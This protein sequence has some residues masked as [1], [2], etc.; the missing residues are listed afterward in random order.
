MTPF[1][2]GERI[3]SFCLSEPGNGSDAGAASTTATRNDQG[4]ALN[5]TKAWITNGYESQASVVLAT[6]DKRSLDLIVPTPRLVLP[7]L[8]EIFTF[9]FVTRSFFRMISTRPSTQ[10]YLV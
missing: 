7:F 4:W 9:S 3:G 2:T 8:N 10:F 1:L 5:G 6:T